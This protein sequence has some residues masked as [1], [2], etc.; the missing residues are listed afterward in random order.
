M[1]IIQGEEML[2]VAQAAGRVGIAVKTLRRWIADGKVPV[3][4][5]G[6]GPRPRIYLR[7]DAV[8]EL[9]QDDTADATS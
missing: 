7:P 9:V 2:T 5:V 8:A 4:R 6:A 1:V 3:V